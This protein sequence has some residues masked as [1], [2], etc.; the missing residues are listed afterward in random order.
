MWTNWYAT[1]ATPHDLHK[2]AKQLSPAELAEAIQIFENELK[3]RCS[4]TSMFSTAY[5]PLWVE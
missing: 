3:R 4:G 1:E 2:L 5:R